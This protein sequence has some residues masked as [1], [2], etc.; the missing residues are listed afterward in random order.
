MKAKMLNGD[1][2]V[3]E[4][5]LNFKFK[6]PIL[7][8]LF[9]LLGVKQTF[10]QEKSTVSITLNGRVVSEADGQIL[11]G[12]TIKIKSTNQTTIT[13]GKGEFSL[14][15]DRREGVLLVSFL[16]YTTKE[17]AIDASTRNL[18]IQLKPDENLLSDVDVVVNTGYQNIPKERATGSFVHIDN[19][20]L[21]RSVSTD[22]IS[23]LKGIA[24]SLLFDERAGGEPKLSIRGRS[25]IFA[26][27]DPLIVVD[28]FPYEGDIS[29]INP[30]DV[31]DVSIL[32][33]A[34]AASIWGVRAGNGV[35]VITT[36]KGKR[37]QP[38]KISVNSNVTVGA[39]PDLFY[40][41]LLGAEA[42]IEMEEMLYG[43]GFYDANLR[44]TITYPL[45]PSA[46]EILSNA[47]FSEDE[48]KSRL[49]IL[50]QNDIRN[51]LD[52]Y[53][54]R[55]GVKQQYAL[56]F[57]GGTNKHSYYVSSGYDKIQA[58]ENGNESQRLSFQA[59]ND[60][61]LH[62][63]LNL[64]TDISLTFSQSANNSGLATIGNVALYERLADDNG[65]PLPINRDFRPVF[66]TN[67]EASGRQ[68]WQYI[69]LEDRRQNDLSARQKHIRLGSHLSY[70]IIEGLTTNLQYQFETQGGHGERLY[71]EE[72]YFV[73]NLVNRYASIK[74]GSLYLNLPMGAI[75]TRTQNN[76]D[77]HNVRAT[78][79]DNRKVGPGEW[80]LLA[81]VEVREATSRGYGD[82]RFGY[83][84]ENGT[85]L[86]VN[87]DSGYRQFPSGTQRLSVVAN[88]KVTGLMDRFRAA[89][90]TGSYLLLNKYSV[91]AS[92]RVDQTNLFGV[93]ANQRTVPLWS[94]G[95]KWDIDK[96]G[97]Y[98]I[99]WLPRLST[100]LT[101]GYNGNFDK[102]ATA[103]V[104]A[105][106]STN[107]Y[108]F[109]QAILG[110]LPNPKLRGEK[111]AVFNMGL[112]FSFKEA[113]ISGRVDYYHRRGRDLIGLA[114]IDPTFGQSTLWGNFSDMTG[115]GVDLE[116]NS[117]LQRGKWSWS[118]HLFLSYSDDK[119]TRFEYP[120]GGYFDDASLLGY[121]TS[122]VVGRP[123]F[124]VY[125]YPW[126]GLDPQT[127]DPLGYLSG[128]PSKDYST[129]QQSM[130]SSD[131][132]RYHG[133][134]TPS[135]FGAFRN[136]IRFKRLSLSANV[137]YKLG[138]YFR[139]SSVNY[140]SLFSITGEKHFDYELRW[141]QPGDEK[142][143]HVPSVIYPSKVQRNDF[144]QNA[145][146][147]VERGDH[148]RLQDL[149]I[150]YLFG[151]CK[152]YAYANNLGLIWRANKHGIDPDYNQNSASGKTSLPAPRTVAFGLQ[153]NF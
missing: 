112:D 29:N 127:G 94:I 21:N 102:T 137:V 78:I 149:Q 110:S 60:F 71:E 89:F 72:S 99:D 49:D 96:E 88:E 138:Y 77:V 90:F 151:K 12:A 57:E 30:N 97:F 3:P 26:N 135:T 144:Y 20:L 45:V 33:D 134:A 27:A 17:I 67:A 22:I 36:K 40:S 81:G 111:N 55:K 136:E 8:L 108:G 153:V 68:N 152:V 123:L 69:P 31:E 24:P 133:R 131:N 51:D 9:F 19:E 62:P 93:K 35:I 76:L 15:T 10:A 106:Y 121:N 53:Y 145:S 124:G 47:Q 92:A 84:P 25:T 2:Y 70:K 113:V 146:I 64:S 143:T 54:Y 107:A 101:Y 73:R 66:L 147:L 6:I 5:K 65:K 150:N 142:N 80:N 42:Q 83:N 82:T 38:L 128:E 56:Q 50:K 44:N 86:P 74:N 18:S 75:M 43:K 28:N 141:R 23:R 48:K 129:L 132:R 61:Q 16:G 37:N 58:T 126:A 14:R 104:T 118:S 34:A 95:G 52:K 125:S 91:S 116:L 117:R 11:K 85:S 13:N 139:R 140:G 103:F 7:V 79:A 119:V 109:R 41:P 115:K 59:R 1:N 100:R 122:P 130:L 87:L 46:V 120:Y 39:K 98:T 63:K 148:I 114:L 105:T 4:I 32:R